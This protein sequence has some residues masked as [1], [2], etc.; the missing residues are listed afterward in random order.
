[1]IPSADLVIK[2]KLKLIAFLY[3][4]KE[5]QRGIIAARFRFLFFYH[6]YRHV[7]FFYS[8]NNKGRWKTYVI[9]KNRHE[10]AACNIIQ[11]LSSGRS[12][13]LSVVNLAS[14]KRFMT[15]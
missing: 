8:I 12:I 1:M 14:I 9:M 3:Q 4:L 11:Y 7:D 2:F 6:K 15:Y 10:A 5:D 13:G